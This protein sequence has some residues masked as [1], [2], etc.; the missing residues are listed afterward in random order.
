MGDNTHGSR[1]SSPNRKLEKLESPDKVSETSSKIIAE[2]DLTITSDDGRTSA[3][4]TI[5]RLAKLSLDSKGRDELQEI[6]DHRKQVEIQSSSRKSLEDI[7]R[8]AC[9][10]DIKGYKELKDL[11]EALY[12]L[13]TKDDQQPGFSDSFG[14][15]R[16][17]RE[18]DR[19][20]P[21]SG[22]EKG[23]IEGF[24]QFDTD[25]RSGEMYKMRTSINPHPDYITRVMETLARDMSRFS[26][27]SAFKVSHESHKAVARK[28]TI[29][30]YY[31]NPPG[32]GNRESLENFLHQTFT[33]DILREGYPGMMKQFGKGMASANESE[34]ESIS[35]TASRVGPMAEVLWEH[36]HEQIPYEEFL[37]K[38][39]KRYRER[40]I[41]P[42]N[43]ERNV[44]RE[45][46]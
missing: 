31:N 23:P 40:G 16:Y 8:K 42:K 21:P 26:F 3:E 41:D 38:V 45:D 4:K 35:F 22:M 5:S 34:D 15:F 13:S 2:R 6:I 36:R 17:S 11:H 19:I 7:A 12:D 25:D 29:I 37:P 28:D 46:W 18:L 1:A 43:P 27:V 24:L 20:T 39:E 32:S 14:E 33:A 30:L 10:L 9:E 44:R